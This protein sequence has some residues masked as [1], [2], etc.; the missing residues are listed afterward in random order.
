MEKRSLCLS[1]AVTF[2]LLASSAASG[3]EPAIRLGDVKAVATIHCIGVKW[4][5]EGDENGSATCAV[6]FRE[7]GGAWHDAMPLYRHAPVKWDVQKSIA[8]SRVITSERPLYQWSKGMLESA[9]ARWLDNYLAGSV[10][11]LKPGT[12]YEV[13]LTLADPDG[14]LSLEKTLAV[15]T[16]TEPVIPATGNVVDVSDAAGLAK[17]LGAA[18]AGDVILVHKGEY[19][20]PFE[21]KASGTAEQPIVI[22]GAGDGEA[23]IK[24][25]GYL[26]EHDRQNCLQISGSWVYVTGLTFDDATTAITIGPG[27][28]TSDAEWKRLHDT[29]TMLHDVVITRTKTMRT[30]Y[31]I[32]GIADRCFIADND[33]DGL[34]ADVKDIDWSEGEGVEVHGSGTVVCYNRMHHLSDAISVYDFTDNQDV[35]NNEAISNSDDGIEVDDSLENNRVWDN[36]FWFPAN[37]GV[38]FQPYIGGPVYIIRNEVIGAREGCSKDRYASSDVFLF[39]NTFIG[40]TAM[41]ERGENWSDLA[42]FDMPMKTCSRNN[43]YLIQGSTTEPAVNVH[44][45]EPLLHSANMDY[46]G[47][48]GPIMIDSSYGAKKID[49]AQYP[50]SHYVSGLGLVI[51]IDTF[52]KVS[53][54]LE[55]YTLVD[56][57]TA[58]ATP[59]PAM[60]DWQADGPAPLYA[61]Q[62]GLQRHRRRHGRAQHHRRLRRQGAGPR[63]A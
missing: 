50:G 62:G 32:I 28:F 33:L 16:R 45:E 36:R 60:R 10:F 49:P 8:D 47:L 13:R 35:Y 63:R 11:N 57:S 18:R 2:A 17:A 41:P 43:L 31:A 14:N 30:Q 40:H 4:A 44:P 19:Q 7:A 58:F 15:T 27:R 20:G 9:E 51:P 12:A 55:H 53:G 25:K 46:D 5:A 22:R 37:N 21:I 48:S 6:A 23:V 61:P 42:V 34:A 38:S 1:V 3:A 26:K 29:G 54:A 59:L 52:R 39:N 24:G 56:P